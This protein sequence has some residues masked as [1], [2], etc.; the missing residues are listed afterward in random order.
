M[1]GAPALRK[2]SAVGE[3]EGSRLRHRVAAGQRV[4]AALLMIT[5]TCMAAARYASV[6]SSHFRC[7]CAN[8]LRGHCRWPRAPE[9]WRGR[10]RDRGRAIHRGYTNLA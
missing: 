9:G 6:R 4:A 8:S 3:S 5:V 10:K 7:G 1:A 2:L